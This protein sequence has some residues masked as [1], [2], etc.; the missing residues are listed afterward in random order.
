[1]PIRVESVI[2]HVLSEEVA[3]DDLSVQLALAFGGDI[4]VKEE[5]MDGYDPDGGDGGENND[6]GEG[7]KDTVD[8]PKGSGGKKKRVL[9]RRETLSLY[10]YFCICLRA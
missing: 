5:P 2:L 8:A 1:M 3:V 10:Q 9:T 4:P 6:V 7:H